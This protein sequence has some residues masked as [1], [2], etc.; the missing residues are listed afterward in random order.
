MNDSLQCF[1][2]IGIRA[3]GGKMYA[4]WNLTNKCPWDCKFCCVSAKKSTITGKVV[5][6]EQSVFKELDLET[7]LEILSQ[8]IVNGIKIDFSGGDPLYFEDDYVVIG[9][10]IEKL[11][12]SMVNVSTTGASF[13][14]RKLGILR[15]VG[16]VEM[17][18]DNLGGSDNP[19]RPKGYN[20]SSMQALKKLAS[21]GIRCSAVTI[22]Y[23][24]TMTKY[25]L[26]S[27]HG[28]LCKNNISQ[29]DI[30]KFSTVGR[31]T[32]H[33]N[34]VVS[35]DEYLEMM[36]FIESLGGPIRIAFQ[37]S[38]RVLAGN[39]TCHAAHESIGIL[40]DGTA[41]S[42]AWALDQ[43]GKPLDGFYL[44]KLPEDNL[45]D[46]L[47]KALES[48]AYKNRQATCRILDYQNREGK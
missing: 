36:Q 12:K 22:L 44:G 11:P 30:L 27:L 31:G 2:Q 41:V 25:N 29:W 37:H 39:Y 9:K 48:L 6:L 24:F 42:C 43:D 5:S 1:N 8:L 38:L 16:K 13:N 33:N 21:A 28:W 7:K 19:Y 18:L 4:I 32:G 15:K 23:P 3:K 35:N 26:L 45:G 34:L 17:T 10:A 14:D 47:K 46:I 20:E 40:P